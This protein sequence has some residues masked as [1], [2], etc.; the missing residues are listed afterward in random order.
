VG[1]N[2][3]FWVL[4]KARMYKR[5]AVYSLYWNGAALEE[6]WRTKDT[7]NYMPDFW[8]DEAKSELLLLQL[9]QREDVLTRAKGASSLQIKKVE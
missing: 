8:F 5:G 3:G 2:D 4:G 6:S 9:T 7:Q 1:K